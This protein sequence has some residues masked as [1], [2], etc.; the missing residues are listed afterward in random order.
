[1]N[2]ASKEDYNLAATILIK[3][4]SIIQNK[5][6]ERC[7]TESEKRNLGDI[8]A[9]SLFMATTSLLASSGIAAGMF[10]IPKE[11]IAEMLK[12]SIDQLLQ[13]AIEEAK[14][15]F[16]VDLEASLQIREKLDD[17]GL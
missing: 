8:A 14:F 10:T 7:I 15:T 12:S 5:L 4:S 2:Q 16:G 3:E 1:M 13:S 17:S 9:T 11:S 6:L